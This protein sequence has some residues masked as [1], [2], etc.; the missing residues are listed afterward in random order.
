MLQP[1]SKRCA[2]ALRALAYAA[3]KHP[4]CRFQAGALCKDAGMPE[5]FTRKVL[6]VLVEGGLLVAH[7]GPGG[8]YSLSRPPDQITLWEIVDVV[9]MHRGKE[10]CIMGFGDCGASVQC[11]IHHAIGRCAAVLSELLAE[12]TLAELTESVIIRKQAST[13]LCHDRGE[14]ND[15][16]R[17]VGPNKKGRSRC[18]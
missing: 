2:Y 10:K 13:H 8:G 12:S 16:V 4:G 9:D 1:Y 14:R 5:P 18:D 15:V 3:A 17:R 11:P 7:R 6:H